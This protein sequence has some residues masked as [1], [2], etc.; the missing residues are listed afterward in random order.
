MAKA[1]CTEWAR[2][3]NQIAMNIASRQGVGADLDS[4][5]RGMKDEG[6]ALDRETVAQ[7]IVD[8]TEKDGRHED[9]LADIV[10]AVKQE[11]REDR[12]LA[13]QTKSLERTL[14]AGEVPVPVK[15]AA[16]LA[17]EAIRKARMIRDT[18]KKKL[19]KSEP[20]QK[21]RIQK[22]IDKLDAVIEAGDFTPKV[23]PV[24]TPKSLELERMEFRR[25]EKRRLINR[26]IRDLKPQTI[27]NKVADVGNIPRAIMTSFDFPPIFRQ[28][29]FLF[30][31]N[32]ILT[33]KAMGPAM[34][35][36]VSR[37]QQ[38]RT[39]REIS[40]RLNAMWYRRSGL[41]II[42]EDAILKDREEAYQ[43]TLIEK[44]RQVPVLGKLA[45]PILAS[46]RGYTTFLNK[47]RADAFDTFAAA[48]APDGNLTLE[49]AQSL[50]K[51]INAVTGRGELP[52]A[53]EN[54]AA[55]LNA[56]IF[57][58]RKMAGTFQTIAGAIDP[59]FAFRAGKGKKRS[60]APKE[61]QKLIR[62][63]YARYM[64]G[65]GLM[66]TLASLAFGDDDQFD[67]E[68]DP[69]S[70]DFGKLRFGNTRIDP[71]GGLSQ[72]IVVLARTTPVVG[73]F[74]SAS[75]QNIR[76]LRGTDIPFG[77]NDALDVVENFFEN[78]FAPVFGTLFVDAYLK[79][80]LRGKTFK[81]DPVTLKGV[82]GRFLPM[83]FGDVRESIQAQG[84]TKG[85]AISLTALFGAGVMTYGSAM[86]TMT[87]KELK[88]ILKKNTYQPPKNKPF[89]RT[90]IVIRGDEKVRV[91]IGEAHRG[92]EGRVKA[93]KAELRKRAG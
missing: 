81:G 32:P 40:N 65:V 1:D 18:L 29:N 83:S 43:T 73:G 4:V 16:K 25:D 20:V 69:R 55:A 15:R 85:L 6:I 36:I 86:N 13:R 37:K 60:R 22:Q 62:R 10:N 17:S 63:Q 7:A 48:F 88:A 38:V 30:F 14:A 51:F 59:G 23:K 57:A 27:M 3:I 50:A 52:S 34:R 89:Q 68:W 41:A 39:M 5:V 31:S 35:A 44:F 33:M 58:P 64:I 74:K 42:E 71:L 24:Q 45:E 61:V 84:T 91:T 80:R 70:S 67:I 19:A 9:V 66:Y 28:G 53:M 56:V 75:T 72:T 78:K 21:D 76:K 54:S 77:M 82:A 90:K 26:R 92:E 2:T 49:Q 8:A 11:A 79:G 12:R 47:L 93:I 87:P 46:E